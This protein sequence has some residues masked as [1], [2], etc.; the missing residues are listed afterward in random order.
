MQAN[1]LK[2]HYKSSTTSTFQAFF[3]GMFLFLFFNFLFLKYVT[4]HFNF[5]WNEAIRFFGVFYSIFFLALQLYRFREILGKV[6]SLKKMIAEFTNNERILFFV[7]LIVLVSVSLLYVYENDALEYF[8]IS[9][10]II[11]DNSLENYPPI[12]TSWDRSLYAPSTHPPYFHIFFSLFAPSN[13]SW[14]GLRF[15]LLL[16]TL[17]MV[18]VLLHR[19]QYVLGILIVLSLPIYIFGIQGLSIETFRLP[20]F[21][22]GLILILKQSLPDRLMS[23]FLRNS[24]GLAMMI[25]TH[26]LGLLMSLLTIVACL[27]VFKNLRMLILQ[28]IGLILSVAFVAPQ[29]ILNT[30]KFGSPVQDSSP[31]LDLPLI[32]FYDDLRT[33][34]QISTFSDMLINGSIRPFIDFSLFGFVFTVGLL[35]SL[36]F[37]LRNYR[38]LEGNPLLSVCAIIVLLFVF[39]QIASS[40][41]GVELLV[42]NVRYAL[43]IFPCLL[44]VIVEHLRVKK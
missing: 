26:S 43:S 23:N 32:A 7:G 10:Q 17:G 28:V 16:M 9:R 3:L 42:K 29:Y 40:I 44:V 13:G 38:S 41:L 35:L 1:I 12:T 24:L 8:G 30:L 39:L 18:L 14:I 19:D 11:Y 6:K 22:S 34:R 25:S 2:L 15:I 21:A 31:I 37:V 20:L 27:I 36:N 5:S 4:T 33:R